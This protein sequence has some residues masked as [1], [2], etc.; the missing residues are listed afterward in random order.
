MLVHDCGVWQGKTSASSSE[1]LVEFRS[2][3]WRHLFPLEVSQVVGVGRILRLA[4]INVVSI[5]HKELLF[6]GFG[7]D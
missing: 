7:I 3:I 1:V 6:E 4:V 2:F 5:A